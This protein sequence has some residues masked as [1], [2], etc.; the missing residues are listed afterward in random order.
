MP[1]LTRFIKRSKDQLRREIELRD[2]FAKI[3]FE[4]YLAINDREGRGYSI[5]GIGRLVWRDANVLMQER[6]DPS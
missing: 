5:G 1:D 3:A 6:N 4:H 2:E